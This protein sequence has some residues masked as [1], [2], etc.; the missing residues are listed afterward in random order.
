[1]LA[2]A[3]EIAHTDPYGKGWIARIEPAALAVE[4]SALLQG[5]AV[6]GAMAEH[7]RLYRIE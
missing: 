1:M 3:P 6:I 7:A 4:R 2:D 5:E